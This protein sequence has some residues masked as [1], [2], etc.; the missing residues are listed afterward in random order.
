[1]YVMRIL[2]DL[3]TFVNANNRCFVGIEYKYDY[4][5]LFVFTKCENSDAFA[6]GN[7]NP[8]QTRNGT[9]LL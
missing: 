9:Q 4:R 1:M 3:F 7:R 8:S 2:V 6:I 5:S